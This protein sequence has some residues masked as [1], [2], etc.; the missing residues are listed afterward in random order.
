[1]Y[2]LRLWCSCPVALRLPYFFCCFCSL[3]KTSCWCYFSSRSIALLFKWNLSDSLRIENRWSG[4]NIWISS[5]IWTL[6]GVNN[7]KFEMVV[8]MSISYQSQ[9]CQ[10]IEKISGGW[11]ARELKTEKIL[12]RKKIKTFKFRH[13]IVSG[14]FPEL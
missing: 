13:Q 3:V 14:G 6:G 10:G 1:M 4:T 5:K 8:S 2:K 12:W 9:K 7:L 11:T